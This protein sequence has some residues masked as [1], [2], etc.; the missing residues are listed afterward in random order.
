MS[1]HTHTHTHTSSWRIVGEEKN[2]QNRD[3]DVD[4]IHICDEYK[5]I[6]EGSLLTDKSQWNCSD[7]S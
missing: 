1:A 7:A 3:S 5:F 6:M 4:A 2:V